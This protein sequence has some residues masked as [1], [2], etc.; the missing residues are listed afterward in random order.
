MRGRRY[1][2]DRVACIGHTLEKLASPNHTPEWIDTLGAIAI[3]ADP[4]AQLREQGC[5]LDT[6]AF[7]LSCQGLPIAASTLAKYLW[8]VRQAELLLSASAPDAQDGAIDQPA[9]TSSADGTQ[10]EPVID[11]EFEDWFHAGNA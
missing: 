1:N 6:I 5:S 3:L 7:H 8:R 9:A 11:E 4:I 10:Q 2:L